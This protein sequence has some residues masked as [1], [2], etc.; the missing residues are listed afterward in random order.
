MAYKLIPMVVISGK[1]LVISTIVDLSPCVHT[2]SDRM[3]EKT[4]G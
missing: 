3:L 2:V 4:K 1:N